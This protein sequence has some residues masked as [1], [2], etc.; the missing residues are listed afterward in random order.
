MMGRLHVRDADG[1]WF[2]GMDAS[3]ALY[4]VLGY[5]RLVWMSTLPG[6]GGLMDAGYRWLARRRLRLGRWLERREKE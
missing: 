2:V 1:R 3:R 5:R 6:V 4:A